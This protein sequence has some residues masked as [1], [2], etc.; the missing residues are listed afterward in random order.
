MN[1][2]RACIAWMAACLPLQAAAQDFP[3]KPMRMVIPFTAGGATDVMGRLVAQKYSDAWG[4]PVVVENR[5]GA[6]G[7]IGME[8]VAKSPADGYTMVLMN[9][10]AA[11]NAALNPNLAFDVTRDF[12]GI[13]LV[14]STPM[15]LIGK[16]GL[17]AGTLAELT[18]LLRKQPGKMSYGS[19]G[20]NGPQHFATE[21]YKSVTKVFIVHTAYRG[22][23]QAV[24]DVVGGQI[25]LAMVS[26][27]VAL[28]HIKTGRLRAYGLTTRKRSPAAPELATFRESG[29][30]ELKD[31][32]VD[33]WY[34]V[35]VPR[36]VP[37]PVVA[38]MQAELRRAMSA[39]DVVQKMA[40][41][42]IDPLSGDGEEI[43]ALLK[44]DIDKFRKVAQYAGIKGD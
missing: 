43:I 26:A 44:A 32:D 15:L 37:Q 10:A 20:V 5:P 42:G 39:P 21:L 19:C 6:G 38:K 28:P 22:C 1:I 27:N 12:A 3:A 7:N 16:T 18:A 17:P 4:Q 35:A 36:G 2:A 23:A 40:S 31:Y 25:E 29:V 9:N 41:S 24:V 34:G 14:A 30:P 13:G 11:T 8:F 33:I